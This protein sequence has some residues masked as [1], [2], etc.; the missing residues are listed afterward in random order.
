MCVFVCVCLYVCVCVC[1]Y[2]CE[3]VFMC[4]YLCVCVCVY[5]CV[6]VFMCVCVYICVC[7]FMYACVCL[8]VCVCLCEYV[9][10]CIYLCVC[11]CVCYIYMKYSQ[12]KLKYQVENTNRF[13]IILSLL[14]LL[15]KKLDIFWRF[16]LTTKKRSRIRKIFLGVSYVHSQLS[17]VLTTQSN[18]KRAV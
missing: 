5:V 2:V 14:K 17:H 9:Y 13:V 10:V 3:S 7:V 4:V 6:S 16:F 15:N 8:C 1:V 18:A 12:L 11:V